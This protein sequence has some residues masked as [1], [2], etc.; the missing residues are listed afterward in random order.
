MTEN[1]RV[2]RIVNTHGLKGQLKVEVLTNF[3]QRLAKGRRLRLKDEWVTIEASQWQGSRM[4]VKLSGIEDID[5]AKSLQ[6]EYLYSAPG[7][8]IELDEDE[9]LVEDLIDMKVVTIDGLELGVVTEVEAYPAQDI[10]IIASP[11]QSSIGSP[12]MIP[13]ADQF[14]KKIDFDSDTITVELIEGMLGEAE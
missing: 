6:W 1:L 7:D 11:P 12:L 13:F 10:L 9:F 2:G 3:D 14:V 8:E 4:L 5:T